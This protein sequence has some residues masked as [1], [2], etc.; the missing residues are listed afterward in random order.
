MKIR[1]FSDIHNDLRALYNNAKA[2]ADLY[3]AAG[4]LVSWA[5]G[6]PACGEVLRPLGKK[7]FVIPGNH[8]SAEDIASFCDEFGF[9]NFHE[10]VL[11]RDGIHFAGLGYS[12]PTPFNTPGEY[13]EDELAVRLAK[14][15]GLN[16]LVLVCHTPPRETALDKT[17]GGIHC[18]SASV[19]S[20][21]D[22]Q[23]PSW[24]FCGHIHE[25]AGIE[26][27]MGKTRARNVG[28]K[29]FSFEI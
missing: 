23:Q 3:F 22:A 26:I 9:E 19:R 24:F 14:F 29:G 1:V 11:E 5:R 7:L 10:G 27:R 16:Q 15:E 21:I 25:A 13:S 17:S 4:D 20:F 8:E 18:G 12:N 28:P 6:L 2:E